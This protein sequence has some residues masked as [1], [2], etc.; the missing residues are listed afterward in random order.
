VSGREVAAATAL[1]PATHPLSF[2]SAAPPSDFY[3]KLFWK[4]SQSP[5]AEAIRGLRTSLLFSTA[6]QPPQVVLVSSA[7]SGEG[8]TTV[9][10]NLAGV[11]AQQG[12]TCLVEGDL[13]RPMIEF[14]MG[15]T[16]QAGLEDVLAGNADIA[17][18]IVPSETVAGLSFLPIKSMPENPS[19]L[20][21]S[22]QMGEV[23]KTLRKTFD[24]VVVDSPP[25]I[26]FSDA[27]SL[28]L[29][30]DGVILV[31]RYGVTTRRSL[32]LSAEMFADILVPV[33]G[34]VLNDMDV[35]SADFHYFHYGYSWRTAGS[36]SEYGGNQISPPPPN[37]PGGESPRRKAKGA[38]A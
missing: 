3:P 4:R 32:T 17:A 12:K 24:Y 6:A 16:A 34:V 2:G 30:S 8:K 9:A 15:V 13:R 26:L 31:S 22:T 7:S 1:Y 28:A 5:E 29:L 20:L 11:L 35:T 38:R 27:R 14:A 23:I 37:S 18:A 19:D 25:V 21:A 33:I 36:K 10:I